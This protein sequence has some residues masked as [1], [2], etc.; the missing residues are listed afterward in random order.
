[1]GIFSEHWK[2]RPFELPT[3][4]KAKL[5]RDELTKAREIIREWQEK[6]RPA[7]D[8]IEYIQ[9]GLK[10]DKYRAERVYWT[11]TKKNDRIATTQLGTEVG[12]THYKAILS[13]SACPLCRKKTDNGNKIFTTKEVQ[14]SGY[15]ESIPFHPGCYCVL[16]PTV[17]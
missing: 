14:K 7:Y 8:I 10:I 6:N 13:P 17:V 1:M 9:R 12:F 3:F 5:S 16:V 15:G 11:E 4:E 2:S